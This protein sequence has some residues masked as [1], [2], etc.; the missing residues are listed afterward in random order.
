MRA[1][2]VRPLT[3]AA[4]AKRSMVSLGEKLLATVVSPSIAMRK[5]P[6]NRVAV[7]PRLSP[8]RKVCLLPGVEPA[9]IPEHPGE[10]H[11]LGTQ[12]RVVGLPALGALAEE[13]DGRG[14]IAL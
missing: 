2:T 7:G 6:D 13:H 1:N 5:P 10:S 11:F 4:A 12:H 9:A 8:H 3:L 14:E